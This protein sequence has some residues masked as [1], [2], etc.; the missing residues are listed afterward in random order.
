MRTTLC[1]KYCPREL[2]FSAALFPNALPIESELKATVAVSWYISAIVSVI[3]MCPG[4]AKQQDQEHNATYL[5][6]QLQRAASE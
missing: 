2:V 1:K 6:L 5:P 4:D 3:L